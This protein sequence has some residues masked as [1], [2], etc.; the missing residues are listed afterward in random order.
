[1]EGQDLTVR[2]GRLWM[3][4]VGRLEPVDVVLRRVDADY[5][6]PLDLRPDSRLGVPGLVEATRLG[7]VS[8]LNPIGAGVL[9]NPALLPFLAAAGPLLLGTE[10]ALDCAP[11]YWCGEP[12]TRRQVLGALDR[13]VLKPIG[14]GIGRASVFGWE[15]SQRQRDDLR[16]RI[17]AEPGQ[18]CG[19][20]PLP[21]STAPV[22]TSRGLEPRQLVLRTFAVAQGGGYRLMTG[23]LARVGGRTGSRF[24]SSSDGALAKDVWVLSR[25]AAATGAA[26]LAG[27]A[28]SLTLLAPAAVVPV[29]APRVAEDLFWLG[30][31]A[32]RAEDTARLL[33]VVHDL[34]EDHGRRPQTAGGRA[35]SV[36]LAATGQV[37]GQLTD[38]SGFDAEQDRPTPP[39][40]ELARLTVESGRPGSLGFA[41]RHTLRVAQ[42]VR[43]QLS[44]DTWIVLGSL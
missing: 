43:E 4:S 1:V 18:W 14:R 7:A 40:R 12:A 39:H 16:R 36:L 10:P 35:L 31:Y 34:A 29:L 33:R 24:V 9:E 22:V 2:E 30:R 6:D 19:Q 17:E 44:L 8:V 25:D 38:T 23:G 37:T 5:C 20:E 3:H 32:E 28:D 15:L 11:T 21:T 42:A 13:L 41:V 27:V 26:G